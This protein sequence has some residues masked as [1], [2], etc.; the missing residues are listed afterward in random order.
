MFYQEKSIMMGCWKQ[1][2]NVLE[3]SQSV[4]FEYMTTVDWCSEQ[5]RHG[6]SNKVLKYVKNEEYTSV[7]LAVAKWY[8]YI[9]SR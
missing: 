2:K 6:E 3:V 5:N 4:Q 7:V 1:M 9:N 8:L